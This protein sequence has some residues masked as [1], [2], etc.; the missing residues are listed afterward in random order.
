MSYFHEHFKDMCIEQLLVKIF[1][2]DPHLAPSKWD[3]QKKDPHLTANDPH[4]L[5]KIFR[6]ACSLGLVM[7]V[8]QSE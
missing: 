2:G 8:T 7:S 1:S 3:D 6:G 5:P 4:Y